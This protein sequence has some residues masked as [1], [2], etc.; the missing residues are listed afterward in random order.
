[1]TMT[2][3]TTTTAAANATTLQGGTSCIRKAKQTV[4]TRFSLHM[5]KG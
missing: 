4:K 3:R 5:L 2:R 1:M